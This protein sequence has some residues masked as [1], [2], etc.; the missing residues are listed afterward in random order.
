VASWLL[1][2]VLYREKLVVERKLLRR[3]AGL[4]HARPRAA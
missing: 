3:R 4:D 1:P 2:P